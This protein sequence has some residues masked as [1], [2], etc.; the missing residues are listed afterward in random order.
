M[1]QVLLAP[2]AQKE[3]DALR[4]MD[5]MLA[6]GVDGCIEILGLESDEFEPGSDSGYSI[7]AVQALRERRAYVF[8]VRYDEEAPGIRILFFRLRGGIFVTGIHRRGELYDP[9]SEPMMRALNYW[10]RRYL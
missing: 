7:A 4:A 8:R 2:E 6:A 3:L 5:E 1:M 10:R 9:L